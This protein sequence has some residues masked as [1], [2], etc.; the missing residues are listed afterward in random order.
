M[1]VRTTCDTSSDAFSPILID[2]YY[3]RC[4]ISYCARITPTKSLYAVLY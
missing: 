3:F 2:M 1:H 4:I